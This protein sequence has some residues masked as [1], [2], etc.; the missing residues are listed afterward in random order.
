M[1][2]KTTTREDRAIKTLENLSNRWPKNLWLFAADGQLNVAKKKDGQHAM[3]DN[4]GV[5]QDYIVSIINIEA[6]GGDW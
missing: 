6:D 2:I 5:D 4:G 3:N 1:I